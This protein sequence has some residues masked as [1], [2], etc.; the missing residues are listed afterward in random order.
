[1]FYVDIEGFSI[2]L[3]SIRGLYIR[4]RKVVLVLFM[5]KKSVLFKGNN[6]CKQFK[7][8]YLFKTVA[9]SWTEY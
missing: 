2:F 3:E 4:R 1:M 6:K 5:F 7:N 9:T 8:K